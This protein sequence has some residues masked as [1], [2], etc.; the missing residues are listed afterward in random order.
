MVACN[1]PRVS[2]EGSE[3]EVDPVVPKSTSGPSATVLHNAAAAK[4][5]A[6]K[7][8]VLE[9]PKTT[10]VSVLQGDLEAAKKK[11]DV[12]KKEAAIE[13]KKVRNAQKKIERVKKKAKVLSNNDLLEVYLMRMKDGQKKMKTSEEVSEPSTS[14]EHGSP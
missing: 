10:M 8:S 1:N 12:A 4:N 2:T 11:R 14:Q 9:A 5:A 6:K 13:T 3:P 7:K